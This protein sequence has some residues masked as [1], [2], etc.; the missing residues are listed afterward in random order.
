MTAIVPKCQS[1]ILNTILPSLLNLSVYIR[2]EHFKR[3][4]GYGNVQC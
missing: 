2:I 3:Y 1:G 4:D